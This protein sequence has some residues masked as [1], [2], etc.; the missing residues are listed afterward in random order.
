MPLKFINLGN[1]VAA[2]I[3]RITITTTSSIKVKPLCADFIWMFI[4][5][6]LLRK[7]KNYNN[8]FIVAMN[9]LF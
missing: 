9:I 2:N 5:N 6:P 4:I 7:V 1:A 8:G 3:P